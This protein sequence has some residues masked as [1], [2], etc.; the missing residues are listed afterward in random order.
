MAYKMDPTKKKNKNGGIN[1]IV[2]GIKKGAEFLNPISGRFGALRKGKMI[3]NSLVNLKKEKALGK[4][5]A[6][7]LANQTPQLP[8]AQV[9]NKN[10]NKKKAK[11]I[12][13]EPVRDPG[14]SA[15]S[16]R[17]KKTS[18]SFAAPRQMKTVKTIRKKASSVVSEGSPSKHM[19]LKK[20]APKVDLKGAVLESGL[21]G[22]SAGG[23]KKVPA[24]P[25]KV[26]VKIKNNKTKIKIKK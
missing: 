10:G 23:K 18:E 5:A 14:L 15:N 25:K 21:A 8:S 1:A 17:Y 9:S 6:N 11:D 4:H 26:K 22:A 19:T 13:R 7:E 24:K 16:R 20:T 3:K 12:T 2:E